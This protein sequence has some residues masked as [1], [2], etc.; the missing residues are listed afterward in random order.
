ME[1]ELVHLHKNK[2]H[3]D[4]C[5]A[6]LNAEWPRS[7][8]AREHSLN[9]SCDGLPCCLVYRQ[10]DSKEVIGFSQVVAV[11]GKDKACLFESVIIHHDLRGKGLGRKL[12]DATEQFARGMNFKTVY[13]NTLD[14]QGFYSHLG[15][16]E[17]GPVVS[18]GA[19]ASRVSEQFLQKLLGTSGDS[20]DDSDSTKAR[21]N[22]NTNALSQH[23]PSS[24]PA[25]PPPPPP[26]PAVPAPPPPPPPTQQSQNSTAGLSRHVIRM[27][28]NAVTWMHKSL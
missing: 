9:K 18:L 4:D 23:P 12:M 10:V 13:L 25:L 14:K 19:N 6:I 28:P 7:K 1:Y 2:R 11:Q 27:D 5:C 22:Q 16:T 8:A 21:V 26:P 20:S 15:Y 24:S 3:F 17:C